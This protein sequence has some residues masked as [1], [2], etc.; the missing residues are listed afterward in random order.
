MM[1]T[2]SVCLQTLIKSCIEALTNYSIWES[3]S[4]TQSQETLENVIDHLFLPRGGEN[5]IIVI[6]DLSILV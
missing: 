3:H 1:I 2:Q 6:G 5:L 4:A